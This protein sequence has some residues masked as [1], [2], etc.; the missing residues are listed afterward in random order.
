VWFLVDVISV[1]L[2]L[3]RQL[4]PTALLYVVFGLLCVQG[5]MNWRRSL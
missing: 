2:Y 3:S 1:P 4:Y 5:A